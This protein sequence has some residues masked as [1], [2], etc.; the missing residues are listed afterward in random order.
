MRRFTIAVVM[1]FGTMVAVSSGAFA[2][3]TSCSAQVNGG[4][5]DG[6]LVVPVGATCTLNGVTVEGGV[7]VK[8]SAV[9]NV[10]SGSK[11]AGSIEAA[12]CNRVVLLGNGITVAGNLHVT[13][14]TQITEVEPSPASIITISGNFICENNQNPCLIQAG[15]IIRGNVAFINNV[16]SPLFHVTIGGNVAINDNTSNLPGAEVAVLVGSVI[17]GNVEVDNN[18]GPQDS[19]VGGNVIQGNLL[20]QGNTPGVS[21]TLNTVDGH[22]LGQCAG[23]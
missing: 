20:C 18:H 19:T 7:L 2:Q 8:S 22:K 5:V 14:C 17:E 9:L 4:I 1:A 23:L 15:T 13:N 11:I 6:N 12:F 21:G 10:F 16:N 3:T